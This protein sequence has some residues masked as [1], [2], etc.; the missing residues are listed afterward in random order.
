MQ[1][2]IIPEISR[3]DAEAGLNAALKSNEL[4]L[5][6][7]GMCELED[8]KWVQNIYL[9]YV[10]HEDD[11]VAGAAVEGLGHLSRVSRNLEKERVIKRLRELELERPALAGHVEF[12]VEDIEHFIQR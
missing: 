10:T 12:A 5:L 3:E 8:W 11:S 2:E 9:E 1:Y 7:L 6:L 4:R